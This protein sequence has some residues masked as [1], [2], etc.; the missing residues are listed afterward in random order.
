MGQHQD[1]IITSEAMKELAS[2]LKTASNASD[3]KRLQC[4]YFRG[5]GVDVDAIA[6]MVQYD[7]GYVK[8][9]WTRYFKGGAKSLLA[10]PRGGRRH[11]NMSKEEESALLAAH[12]ESAKEGKLLKIAPLHQSLCKK[13]GKKV[14]LSSAYR[15]AHRHGWRSLSRGRTIRDAMQRRRSISSFFSPRLLEEPKAE[16]SKRGLPLRVMF[17][18]E[19]RFGASRSPT[20]A[21]RRPAF[22]LTCR[23][24]SCVNIRTFTVRFHPRTARAISLSCPPWTGRA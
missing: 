16:A 24:K 10:K 4:V 5:K 18:D 20:P 15:L 23:R 13:L 17:Q 21:G 11:E 12:T 1:K 22:V 9:V 7:S 6:E 2:L 19:A 14:A 3:V 8:S